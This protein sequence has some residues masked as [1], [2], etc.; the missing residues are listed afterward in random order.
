MADHIPS[1][2]LSS[3]NR[4]PLRL[5]FL[6]DA[7]NRAENLA[8]H[9]RNDGFAT[10]V[11]RITSPEDLQESLSA[12]SWDL[13]LAFE[14]ATLLSPDAVLA[15]VIRKGKDLPCILLL[16][17]EPGNERITDWLRAHGTDA[18]PFSQTERL[19]LVCMRE[20]SN[21]LHR[22]QK[23]HNEV[24]LKESEKRCQLLLDS[25]VDAIAYVHEGMHIH[26]NPAYVELFGY[27]DPDDLTGMPLIDMIH[28]DDQ[29]NLKQH[30]RRF[31]QGETELPPME[32]K[33]EKDDGSHFQ[34]VLTLSAAKW[35]GEQCTQVIIRKAVTKSDPELAKK[36][37]AMQSM[38]ILTTLFNRDYFTDQLEEAISQVQSEGKTFSVMDIRLDN[39]RDMKKE[40]GVAR[41]DAY[42][43]QV[44]QQLKPVVQ[45]QGILA[46]YSDDILLALIDHDLQPRL[47]ALGESILSTVK[48]FV[49]T[50]EKAEI[51]TTA[52][53]GIMPLTASAD[54]CHYA[55][56]RAE[57]ACRTSRDNGG[58]QLAFHDHQA[59]LQAMAKEGDLV[60]LV[61]HALKE[62]RF[63]LSF[64]PV[65]NLENE[66]EQQYEVFSRLENEQGET[67]PASEFMDASRR[68]GL[69]TRIDRWV[70]LHSIKTLADHRN[71]GN[72]TRLFIT[73]GA[74]SIQDQTLP[75][76]INMALK[77]AKLP[78]EAL[79]F[80]TT[81]EDFTLHSDAALPVIKSLQMLNCGVSITHFGSSE[82]SLALLDKMPVKMIKLNAPFISNLEEGG[83]EAL[84]HLQHVVSTLRQQD[85]QV[86]VPRIES[87][88]VLSILWQCDVNYVQGY[89]LQAP[90]DA[91]EYDFQ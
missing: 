85:K 21:L 12:H 58:D 65:L 71:Q 17:D 73:L 90:M 45:E 23:Q 4:E 37:A 18:L 1:E 44:A 5:L 89:Y 33:G 56:S 8:S 25:S 39:F 74:D 16:D 63:K 15:E 91:M 24:A 62:E 43:A 49:I 13:L 42:L 29:G 22:R 77:A 83:D 57:N 82:E 3:E 31:Q 54:S 67:I 50:I 78:G 7:R 9:F 60:A 6:E 38:D 48:D 2:H 36:L 46:R 88:K 14:N 19:K 61:T 55:L 34:G 35:D 40:L 69:T 27:G 51:Q 79:I 84:Q 11:H 70:I 26:A 87:N 64:Q 80:Q 28:R 59:E 75:S 72:D 41:A 52:S 32:F 53:L 10:R 47:Q 68:A 20:W 66:E 76:W 86:L 30:I 81:E